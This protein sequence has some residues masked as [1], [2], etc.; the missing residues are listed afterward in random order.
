MPQIFHAYPNNMWAF[1]LV[2]LWFNVSRQQSV[3]YRQP[4]L[5]L[6]VSHKA[7]A[8]LDKAL[9]SIFGNILMGKGNDPLHFV[10]SLSY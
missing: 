8:S 1:Y 10:S 6:S 7:G 9:V 4:F 2:T 5:H 3:P